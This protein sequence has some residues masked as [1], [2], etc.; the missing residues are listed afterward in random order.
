MMMAR[1][2]AF[3]RRFSRFVESAFGIFDALDQM[4]WVL[5]TEAGS[6][7]NPVDLKRRC[8]ENGVLRAE[9]TQLR[10]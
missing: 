8:L 4:L 5:V 7:R 6:L 3:K 2:V 10:V 1:A 9:P